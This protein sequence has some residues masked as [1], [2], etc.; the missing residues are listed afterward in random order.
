MAFNHSN[1]LVYDSVLL[2][3]FTLF[4]FAVFLAPVSLHRYYTIFIN[5][6]G[7]LLMIWDYK[8]AMN[9][10]YRV[11]ESYLLALPL[12]GG[13]F[14]HFFVLLL[15]KHKVKK[16]SFVGLSIVFVIL[17]TTVIRYLTNKYIL[18]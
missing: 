11:S 10:D 17:Y 9:R 3:C 7:S 5:I 15:L 6:A 13:Y 1:R 16:L 4:I 18:W 12:L 2:V 14:G 8:K